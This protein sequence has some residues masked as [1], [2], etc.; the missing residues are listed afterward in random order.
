MYYIPINELVPFL[1]W[2]KY[3]G[4]DPFI[5][6]EDEARDQW[7]TFCRIKIEGGEK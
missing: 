4:V 3:E 2:L 5:L 6:T 1:T 7:A